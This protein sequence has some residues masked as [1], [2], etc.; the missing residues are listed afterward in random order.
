MII[1]QVA[2]NKSSLLLKIRKLNTQ[3]S[4]LFTEIIKTKSIL[5]TLSNAT[6]LKVWVQRP[7]S[8]INSGRKYKRF[9]KESG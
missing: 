8:L 4:Q 3:T 2:S 9:K 5:Q 7:S 6:S 1:E